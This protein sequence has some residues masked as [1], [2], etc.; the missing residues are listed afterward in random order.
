M[1]Q[2]N[3]GAGYVTWLGVPRDQ[4]RVEKGEERLVRYDS[5][6][7]GCRSFCGG[8]GTSL[9]CESTHHPDQVDIPLANM[10]G[11]ID[12]AP[13]AHVYFDDRAD[14]V[15]ADDGL[16]RLGGESGMEPIEES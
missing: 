3:H 5:S 6:D 9:F 11:P 4:L 8:C 7:H 13:Q 1:C 16:P 10:H 2:R 14:W 15:F 12:L